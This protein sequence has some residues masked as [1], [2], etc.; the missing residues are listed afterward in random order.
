MSIVEFPGK[1][2]SVSRTEKGARIIIETVTDEKGIQVPVGA[3]VVKIEKAQQEMNFP[4]G[5]II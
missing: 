3:V 4:T 1:V 2:K 5:D